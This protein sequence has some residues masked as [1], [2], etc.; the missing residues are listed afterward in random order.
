MSDDK[1][2]SPDN[3]GYFTAEFLAG[4]D[5]EEARSI[6]K[7]REY[8][9]EVGM[10]VSKLNTGEGAYTV[11]ALEV[12]LFEKSQITTHTQH[13]LTPHLFQ[14]GEWDHSQV[15]A[16]DPPPLLARAGL[17]FQLKGAEAD[18]HCRITDVEYMASGP[19]QSAFRS[20]RLE[21]VP[22]VH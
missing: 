10:A 22:K 20:L 6:N 18:L 2:F 9:G 12:W 17:V 4:D 3:E 1:I 5:F 8:L 16:E 21:L 19:D 15:Q 13:L 14:T 11:S 7:G